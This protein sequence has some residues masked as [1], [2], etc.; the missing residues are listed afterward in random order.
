MA[1]RL[2]HARPGSFILALSLLI[3]APALL[4]ASEEFY[5]ANS[6]FRQGKHQKTLEIIDK[7]ERTE[8][9]GALSPSLFYIKGQ[10]LLSLDRFKDALEVLDTLIQRFPT[11]SQAGTAK[12]KV[13]E[14][15]E[16]QK[17]YRALIEKVSPWASAE[18]N[19]VQFTRILAKA[20]VRDSRPEQAISF[21]RGLP[22]SKATGV[23]FEVLTETHRLDSFLAGEERSFDGTTA[24][25]RRLGTLLGLNKDW[26]RAKPYLEKCRMEKQE[27]ELLQ[28][29]IRLAREARDLEAAVRYASDLSNLQPDNSG[30]LKNLGELQLEMQQKDQAL[31]TWNRIRARNPP[32]RQAHQLFVTILADHG[33]V[34]E[35][36]NAVDGARRLFGSPALFAEEMGQLL[37]R[38]GDYMNATTEYLQL[39]GQPGDKGRDLILALAATGLKREAGPSSIRQSIKGPYESCVDATLRAADARP[40]NLDL[41][42]LLDDLYQMRPNEV[43]IKELADK[44]VKGFAS[45]TDQTLRAARDFAAEGRSLEARL[46]LKEVLP[47]IGPPELWEVTLELAQLERR[48]GAFAVALSLTQ[49]LD[50]DGVSEAVRILARTLSAEIL[51]VDLKNH[52]KA[53]NLLEKLLADFPTGSDR[54]RWTLL[55]GRCAL[56]RFDFKEAERLFG[57]LETRAGAPFQAEAL[58]RLATVDLA[59]N[60]LDAA[61]ER[62]S[63]LVM[64]H[65]AAPAANDAIRELF[66]LSTHKESGK[67]FVSA[68]YFAQLLAVEMGRFD[69]YD[70][71]VAS[72]NPSQIPPLFKADFL[73]LSAK[74]ARARG[75]PARAL[76]VLAELMKSQTE[77]PAI[78]EGLLLKAEIYDRDVKDSAKAKAT[79]QDYLMRYPASIL[80]EEIRENLEGPAKRTM[81]TQGVDIPA[82]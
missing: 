77:G 40:G 11:S 74:A 71:R 60:R 2:A 37:V 12:L 34:N 3:S 54:T 35:A 73:L 20:Y 13:A 10:C 43:A 16:E 68:E 39:V 48:G 29:M 53:R 59:S 57:S 25:A 42:Y 78:E 62:L 1:R 47:K 14:V 56:A 69:E 32:D 36:V 18:T 79:L 67:P 63:T 52:E 27:P 76:D 21:L 6:Y 51:L 15:L 55:L 82:Q 19:D 22:G 9:Q 7:L 70:R 38:Q 44:I 80:C 41:Y 31:A 65:P 33:F 4:H 24:A 64:K 8:G 17:N 28:T 5:L 49:G 61:R 50:V 81:P 75:Q 66:F 26:K 45:E 23:L 30:H 72:I 58:H 46:V